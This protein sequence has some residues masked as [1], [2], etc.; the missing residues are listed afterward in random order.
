MSTIVKTSSRSPTF[1]AL[2]TYVLEVIEGLAL[3]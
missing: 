1:K 2:S 3:I